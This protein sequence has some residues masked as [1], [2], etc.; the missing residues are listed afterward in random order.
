MGPP[1][2]Q[3]TVYTQGLPK[4]S[5]FGF[6]PQGR[7]WV[8]TAAYSDD[9]TD[10][11]YLV[12]AAGATPVKVIASLHTP[13]GLLWYQQS[14]YV[15]SKE[16][17]DAYSGFDG[18]KFAEHRGI[19]A[20]PAGVGEVNGIA[21]SPDGRIVMGIS[22]PCD[23]CAPTLADSAAIVSF[24][25][26]GSDLRIDASHIRAPVGLTYYPD[27]SD[28]FVTMNQRDDLG[29]ATPGDWLSLVQQGQ[30]W[31][32]PDCYGQ[33][34][35]AC[36]GVPA[37]VAALDKHG[38]VDGVAIV[39]GQ[40]GPAVGTAAIVAEWSTGKVQQVTLARSGPAY[41]GTV[42]PF[43]TGLQQPVPVILTPDG[44]LL[45]GD[46]GTGTVYRIAVAKAQTPA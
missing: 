1:G 15:A 34:G 31:G 43:L 46:W 8:A 39:T 28:L 29:D 36:T 20:L 18:T 44:A 14:L 22:A 32:F 11:V 7:L 25:P 10:G 30:D 33:G 2:L 41:T 26:D 5:A 9:G 12:A 13:L 35:D 23:H 21:L 38:A 19:L 27:T 42:K 3:V 24:Q 6:D 40:L 4:A 17:V 45:V 37:P 16:R